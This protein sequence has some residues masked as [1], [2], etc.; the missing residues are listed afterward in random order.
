MDQ[1]VPAMKLNNE[2]S[3]KDST[4]KS[5]TPT[6]RSAQKDSKEEEP[7]PPV[8][9]KGSS[10][11]AAITVFV[12]SAASIIPGLFV[13]LLTSEEER[14]STMAKTLYISVMLAIGL[15]LWG[16]IYIFCL[17]LP[18]IYVPVATLLAGPSPKVFAYSIHLESMATLLSLSITFCTIANLLQAHLIAAALQWVGLENFRG[19][20]DID[21][22]AEEAGHV[23]FRDTGVIF[24]MLTLAKL[25]VSLLSENFHQKA[26]RRR[27]A[28][29]NWMSKI[30]RMLL[31][32]TDPI[33]DGFLAEKKKETGFLLEDDD[34][35]NILSE[36]EARVF[37][38]KIF[39]KTAPRDQDDFSAEDIHYI[40]GEDSPN[41]IMSLCKG[42][43]GKLKITEKK[44]KDRVVE[45]FKNR[46]ALIKGLTVSSSILFKME[47]L[48]MFLMFLL[49]VT[50][51]AES[52][53]KRFLG[54]MFVM[55][56]SVGL[57]LFIFS[58]TL[59]KIFESF[60]FIMFMHPF[61]CGDCVSL[62]N[63][64]VYIDNIC[65]LYTEATTAADHSNNQYPNSSIAGAS[66]V[67]HSRSLP[68]MDQRTLSVKKVSVRKLEDFKAELTEYLSNLD[69]D[70]T[71]YV[72]IDGY[73]ITPSS[74]RFTFSVEYI[75]SIRDYE[76]SCERRK[77][78]ED[79]VQLTL[80][81]SGLEA[82]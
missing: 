48:L 69:E 14:S 10:F 28:Q 50:S 66:I 72:G 45:Y 16:T 9:K 76:T 23:Y 47:V 25:V 7:F 52:F 5:A 29:S 57:G 30:L 18:A 2:Y 40:F 32:A 73:E 77:K 31:Y 65:I 41:V 8:H 82:L 26:Y 68:Y 49:A 67:N 1:E 19:V 6:D 13:A 70:F 34:N 60:I 54:F 59:T 21:P 56:T 27:I 36:K 22:Y 38:R 42:R 55:S 24:L 75:E 12:F 3:Q 37:A 43:G 15:F 79:L 81:R 61:D 17:L 51:V 74:I 35:L 44:M 62:N 80:E 39:R 53:G 11:G 4:E 71:G 78:L 46:R 33:D 63:K 58:G 20:L 64:D